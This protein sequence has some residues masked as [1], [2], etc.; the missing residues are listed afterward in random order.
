MNDNPKKIARVTLGVIIITGLIIA[1]LYNR[2]V[3]KTNYILPSSIKAVDKVDYSANELREKYKPYATSDKSK[4]YV[5]SKDFVK[6]CVLYPSETKFIEPYG[7]VH[8]KTG[9]NECT[10]LGKFITKNTYG[11][12]IEYVYKIWLTHNGDEWED[13][14]NWQ[15]PKLKIESVSTGETKVFTNVQ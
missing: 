9:Q 1:L 10:V 14:N 5:I 13:I 7:Y 3:N 8:E 2:E 11:V 12:K 4:S 15:C 6:K